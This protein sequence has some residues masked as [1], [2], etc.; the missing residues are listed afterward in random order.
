[1][2]KHIILI[3]LLGL[4]SP[5][6]S[7]T[8]ELDQQEGTCKPVIDFY[9]DNLVSAEI[10]GQGYAGVADVGGISFSNINPASF[11]IK[12]DAQIYYEYGLKN[13]VNLFSDITNDGNE[14][15]S[16]RSG[17]AAAFAYKF[18]EYVQVGIMYSAKSSY[19]MDLG[20]VYNTHNGEILETFRLNEKRYIRSV[21]IPISYV[22]EKFRFGVG[23]NLDIYHSEINNVYPLENGSLASYCGELDFL[24][25]RPKLGA[26]YSPMQNLS[27]GMSVLIPVEKKLTTD[28]RFVCL[29]FDKNIFPM[30]IL[31]GTKFSTP[32][33][34]LSVLFDFSYKQ[35]SEMPEFVDSNNFH[36][37]L[38][39]TPFKKLQIRTGMF[40]NFDIRN[41][42]YT[43]TDN[44]G[45]KYDYW[46]D[47]DTFED[48]KFLTLGLSYF[49]RRTEINLAVVD[50]S[51]LTDSDVKQTYAKLGFTIQ[52]A[53]P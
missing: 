23:L 12:N 32:N 18:T 40:T 29:E 30:E 7:V 3:I 34:P 31:V 8:F 41:T 48:R 35:Y 4:I 17:V 38:E 19:N 43:I 9:A 13:D 11:D 53:H 24:L 14:V 37:G 46:V 27:F 21:N 45:N 36:F 15:T 5:L 2:L 49:W 44:A 33:I 20:K 39:Y 42:D 10:A 28:C 16:Y 47:S 22:L 51:F 6:L 26:I 1:M 50:N 52:L 25:F